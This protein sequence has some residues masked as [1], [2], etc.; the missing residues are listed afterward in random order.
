MRRLLLL[1]VSATACASSARTPAPAGPLAPDSL[2]LIVAGTTDVHGWLRGWDY[3]ANAADSTRGLSRIATIVDSLRK[4]HPDRVV[5]VDAGDDL[6]GT[7]ITSVA[8]R[9]SLRPNPIISAMNAM[10]YDAAVIGNHEF[11]YGLGYLNRAIAQAIFPFLA[12]NVYVAPPATR[13]A[14]IPWV[15]LTK[16]GVRV[17]V[18]G[19]TTP[20]SMVWDGDKL[21]GRLEVR[22][23]VPDVRTAVSDARSHGADVVVVALHSGLDGPSSY[24]TLSTGIASENASARV[25]REV[26]GIDVLVF[27]HSHR[28]VPD[29]TIGTTLVTQP[30]NWAGSLS[31][32][33]L[34]LARHGASWRV[35]S[36]SANVIRARGHAEHAHVLAATE[37]AHTRAIQFVTAPLG[38]TP[39]AWRADSARV[40]DTPIIDFVLEVQR[41]A[42]G[43]DLASA[44]AFNLNADF[45]PGAV[46]MAD[47]AEL[48][49]YENNLLRAV[50]ISGRQ[51]KD[52]LEF[53]TRYFR[54]G[55]R[56]DSLI[57]PSVPGFNFDIVSGVDYTIDVSRPIGARITRL[58]RNGRPVAPADS[59][60]MALNDYRQVGGGG[61]AMLRGA[62]LV[63]DQGQV[64]R[65]LLVDEVQRKGVL[66]H[67]DYFTANWRLEPDSLVGAA[68]RSMRRLP[69]D[70]PA[71]PR[72]GANAPVT[73]PR[74][75]LISTNDLHGY[76]EPWT[77][78]DGVRKGG[79]AA[80]ATVVARARAECA[81]P[82]C[83]SLLLDGGDMMQGPALSALAFGKPVIEVMNAIGYDAAAVGNHEF[84]WGPD[85]L[86]A[87]MREA[88]FPILSA[89]TQTKDGKDV[90]WLPNDTLLVRGRYKIGVIGLTTTSAGTS[91][92]AGADG[93]A[94]PKPAAIV[95]SLSR[96]L[97][98]R[99]ADAVVIVAHTGARC[100]ADGASGC[101]GEIVDLAKAVSRR[102]DAIVSGH[103]HTLV[104]T[105][106]DGV[107]IIQAETR[108]ERIAIVD[109]PLARAS[110]A[111]AARGAP[112]FA[113]RAVYPDS[114]P[115]DSAVAAIVRRAAESVGR[116]TAVRVTTLRD[117]LLRRGEE[118]A[119][120]R[121]IA[122]AH[123][124]VGR[125]DIGVVNNGGIR[126]DL[127]PGVVTYGHLFQVSPF[128]N[129]M[130]RLTL[131]GAAVR[132]Y[133]ETLVSR[134]RPGVHASGLTVRYDTSRAAGSR[135][136]DLRLS[137][138]T[139]LSDSGTYVLVLNEF[140]ALGGDNFQLIAGAIK[141]EV[142]DVTDV[143]ALVAYLRVQPTPFVA[144][145]GPRLVRVGA[146]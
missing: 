129:R 50:K 110:A 57:D 116:R 97:R 14:Y 9:D 39:V 105:T 23:L 60:T 70:R 118:H 26:S 131:N 76:L 36:R 127:F 146:P 5:L 132:Q 111:G 28:E 35:A 10:R 122:D 96:A 59:L 63:Y 15:M 2:E 123:R 85:T 46:T 37:D 24:D 128:R 92:R 94:F 18:V 69:Y 103:S 93:F 25:A 49:P 139:V 100:S 133:F 77:D 104:N 83:V 89:N 117:S 134:E 78:R 143:D 11:N 17:A 32:V 56:P 141:R 80:L 44:A 16:S 67:E 79:S 135:I 3:F 38:T 27:G 1:A 115:A 114:V 72:A 29:T 130:H 106:V 98:A 58:S 68:Y 95:D 112:Y 34:R 109:I 43:S 113:G 71:P 144:P 136:L 140:M 19:G 119:L 31:V 30:R 12:A 82:D 125:G 107:P 41:R 62:P 52:Y 102:V 74:L 91:S 65:Q 90:P 126:D 108:S 99:G 42:A 120:G 22:D 8:L 66:R 142:L 101:H 53:S 88:R 54:E 121:V 13:H 33:R 73:G 137:N 20:G 87:R 55:G 7:P 145:A 45:G 84:D 138:G 61:Y 21:R 4:A 6:Q 47:V 64:I 81:P 51:L 48:Y 75:R 124:V 40:K 86:R